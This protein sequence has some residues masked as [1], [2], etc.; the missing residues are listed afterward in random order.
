MINLDL[1]LCEVTSSRH[2]AL[3]VL[4]RYRKDAGQKWQQH[5]SNIEKMWLTF[6]WSFGCLIFTRL[7]LYAHN[8]TVALRLFRGR[9]HANQA[10][11]RKPPG[12]L[13]RLWR[14]LGPY[15]Y[16]WTKSCEKSYERQYTYIIFYFYFVSRSMAYLKTVVTPMLMHWSYCSLALSHQSNEVCYMDK[17]DGC[18]LYHF[19]ITTFSSC[20]QI[21]YQQLS[22]FLVP[23]FKDAV[24]CIIMN[25]ELN[26][27]TGKVLAFKKW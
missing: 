18:T 5:K 21:V 25:W 22:F 20:L 27:K 6:S 1:E 7:I 10:R 23:D 9:V 8:F 15:V 16:H 11:F 14:L 19:Q 26:G 2:I 12:I 3:Q 24:V 13:S 17:V 4:R